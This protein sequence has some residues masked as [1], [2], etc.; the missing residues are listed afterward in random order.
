MVIQL[1]KRKKNKKMVLLKRVAITIIILVVLI[2]VY[3]LYKYRQ[4]QEVLKQYGEMALLSFTTSIVT[5]SKQKV[6]SENYDDIL[7]TVNRDENGNIESIDYDMVYAMQLSDQI[8][9]EAES[10]INGVLSG[11]YEAK[12]DSRYQKNLEMISKNKGLIDKI[13]LGT[14]LNEPLLSL[15][16]IGF[17]VKFDSYALVFSN[18]TSSLE[19]Y[20]INHIK[21]ELL[22]NIRLTQKM[23]LPLFSEVR[24][25]EYS[26]PI[27][28][29]IVYGQLPSYYYNLSGG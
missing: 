12:D 27:A 11:N 17:P 1:Q 20:G 14:I 15:L 3:I 22:L 6:F 7:I 23:V 8:M 24:T 26:F 4:N 5:Q 21:I 18:V 25:I 10:T 19:T 9:R 13:P 16:P 2:S 29:K 28:L